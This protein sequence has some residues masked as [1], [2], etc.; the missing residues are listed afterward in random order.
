VSVSPDL[1]PHKSSHNTVPSVSSDFWSYFAA[2]PE[3][4]HQLLVLFSDR[5][6]TSYAK[7]NGYSGHAYKWVN[8]KGEWHYVQIHFLSDKGVKTFTAE[9]GQEMDGANPDH[10]TQELFE[11]IEKGDFPTWLV[12]SLD[13][14]QIHGHLPHDS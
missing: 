13:T 4:A 12:P 10:N 9:A 1:S 3:C 5:G 8:E 11:M 2:N 6:I 14:A 7:Q